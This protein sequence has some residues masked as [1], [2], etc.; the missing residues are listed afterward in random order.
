MLYINIILQNLECLALCPDLFI[1]PAICNY[2]L[3]LFNISKL[4]F[5]N[6]TYSCRQEKRNIYW[7]FRPGWICNYSLWILHSLWVVEYFL[8]RSSFLYWYMTRVMSQYMSSV[9]FCPYSVASSCEDCSW[10][11]ESL[12]CNG[13]IPVVYKISHS[14]EKMIIFLKIKTALRT[15]H[16]IFIL[17]FTLLL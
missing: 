13:S 2:D 8:L 3:F 4:T 11:V 14:D 6:C 5:S 1:F 10:H 12:F 9:P 15:K 16:S 17:N 7:C